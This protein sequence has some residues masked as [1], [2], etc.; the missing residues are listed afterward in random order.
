MSWG[1]TKPPAGAQVDWLHPT[2]RGLVGCWLF[3]E[4]S[5][6]IVNDL[7]Q[8]NNG[9]G[10]AGPSWSNSAM[11]FNGTSQYLNCGTSLRHNLTTAY[12]VLAGCRPTGSFVNFRN[13]FFKGS[14]WGQYGIITFSGGTWQAQ[15]QS[16]GLSGNT[17]LSLDTDYQLGVSFAGST[18]R[19]WQNGKQTNSGTVGVVSQPTVAFA[20]GADSV[21]L[22]YWSGLVY[23]TF[24]WDRALSAGEIEYIYAEPYSFIQSPKRRVYS[25]PASATAPWYYNLQQALAAG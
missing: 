25:L 9:S 1:R 18:G 2:S 20:I 15:F 14:A 19:T 17:T 13:L 16:A 11:L 12:T 6:G 24:L 7:T 23:Y 21:N 8:T 22:R 3:N 10:V 4:G 5:G